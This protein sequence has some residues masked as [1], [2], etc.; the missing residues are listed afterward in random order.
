MSQT[1]E[2]VSSVSSVAESTEDSGEVTILPHPTEIKET[3]QPT[4]DEGRSRK[5]TEKG[6]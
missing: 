6:L 3:S 1:T 2:D 5:F 4:I